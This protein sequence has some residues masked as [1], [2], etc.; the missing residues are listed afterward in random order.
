MMTYLKHVGGKK[1]SDLK[2][3]NFKEIQVLYEKVKRSDENFIAIGFAEDERIIKDVNKKAT[4]TKKDGSIKEERKE[5]EST[6]K[7]KLG[8]RKKM[9]SRKRRFRQDTSQDDN[10]DSEK[11]N[12][13]LRL[14]LTIAPDEDKEV[15]YE[16]LDK[17]Y[18]IIEW[19]SEHLGIKPQYDEA[20][21]LEEINLNVVIRSSGQRRYFSTLMKVLSIFYR[22]DLNV[23]YQLVMDRYKD[24]I[25]YGFDRVL[26]G[27]L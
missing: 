13:E 11:E 7:R 16:I 15:D 3:K 9:K 2:T 17:K 1:H 21:D 5:E 8:T 24:E 27:D 23:V 14:C 25:P 6:K 22:D 12:D 26:W 10:I 4:G 19:K 20:K 18:P